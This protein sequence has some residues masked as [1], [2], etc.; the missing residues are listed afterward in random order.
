VVFETVIDAGQTRL[1]ALFYCDFP[2]VE[3]DEESDAD[4]TW[5]I[6]G[7]RSARIFY[8]ELAKIFGAG[9]V[10]LGV[11]PEV[12]TELAPYTC[13]FATPSDPR[14]IGSGGLDV[15]RLLAIAEDCQGWRGNTDLN[16]WQF[17]PPPVLEGE[18][19][20][21]F[22][23]HYNFF[24]QTRW[25]Y[26]LEQGGYVRYQNTPEE[27]NVFTPSIDHG[28]G[29]PVVRQNIL[30]LETPHTV[31]NRAGTIIDF[32]LTDYGGYA[33][34]LRDGMKYR[35]C[36][37]TE[38]KYYA[39]RSERYRPFVLMDCETKE[40]INLAPGRMWVNV[41][42]PYNVG[43]AWKVIEGMD[44]WRVWHNQPIYTGP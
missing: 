2:P 35:I 44:F 1:Q 5:D 6:S 20:T 22:L 16:I 39:E 14:D 40:P 4:L 11:S 43:Y 13:A 10:Y 12:A 3:E 25:M 29:N 9:L 42:D 7:A 17:G 27:P 24:N 32:D 31:L 30:I 38:S 34:L 41:V 26:D 18:F 37:S 33:F 21:N 19:V 23:M 36:W 8:A 15:A 28:T